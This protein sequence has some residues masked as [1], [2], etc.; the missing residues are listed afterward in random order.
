MRLQ[1]RQ[2]GDGSRKNR[3]HHVVIV[4]GGVE[5]T[6]MMM[7]Q[8]D[9]RALHGQLKK[10]WTS[11]L[12]QRRSLEVSPEVGRC[13]ERWGRTLKSGAWKNV[14]GCLQDMGDS[15]VKI[16]L[17]ET[18]GKGRAFFEKFSRQ[19]EGVL[20]L[21]TLLDP[22][23]I[24]QAVESVDAALCALRMLTSSRPPGKMVFE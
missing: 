20:T 3:D 13:F 12:K 18:R 10:G 15:A 14:P 17:E 9:R 22:L 11:L 8:K 5:K 21:A 2:R 6:R 16:V 23:Q 19:V 24:R 1:T 4:G 7:S